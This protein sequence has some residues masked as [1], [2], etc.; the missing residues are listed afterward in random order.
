M[1]LCI[2][3]QRLSNVNINVNFYNKKSLTYVNDCEFEVLNSL[4]IVV[5]KAD[6]SCVSLVLCFELFDCLKEIRLS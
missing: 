1:Y 4:L 5:I 2:V 3:I 6:C